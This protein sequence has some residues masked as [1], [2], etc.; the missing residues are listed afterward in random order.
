MQITIDEVAAHYPDVLLPPDAEFASEYA[1]AVQ[2]GREIASTSSVAF[3]A[4]C[5][6]AMPWLPQ[7]H[8]ALLPLCAPMPAEGRSPRAQRAD[9]KR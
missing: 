3:V 7:T 4:I 2:F 6:N 9:G 5:R 1:E 8:C